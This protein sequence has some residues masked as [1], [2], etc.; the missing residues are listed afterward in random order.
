MIPTYDM[1]LRPLLALADREEITRQSATAAMI[2]EFGLTPEEAER[3]IPSGRATYI[4]WAMSFLT[5]GQRRAVSSSGE[6]AMKSLK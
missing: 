4:G 3:K 2:R 1:L 6:R 5:K